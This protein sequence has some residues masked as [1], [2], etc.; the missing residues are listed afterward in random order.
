MLQGITPGV[1]M[2]LSS[3]SIPRWELNVALIVPDKSS[4]GAVPSVGVIGAGLSGSTSNASDNVRLPYTGAFE[5]VISA[6]NATYDKL[7][8]LARGLSKLMVWDLVSSTE[9]GL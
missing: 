7:K 1:T 8:A 6:P 5:S 3:P 9:L 2:I 4:N